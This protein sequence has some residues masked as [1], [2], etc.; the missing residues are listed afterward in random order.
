MST[1]AVTV[2]IPTYNRAFLLEASLE[3]ILA[4][5]LSPV[6]V[7]V[8]DDGSSD[9]TPDL[10]SRMR[11]RIEH[12]RVPQGGKSRAV[13]AGLPLVR[14][15]YLWVFDDDDIAAP[16]ALQRFVAPLRVDSALGFTFSRWWYTPGLPDGGLGQPRG[17]SQMPDVAKRGILAPLLEANFI[18]GASLFGRSSCYRELGGF[19][20][21]MLRSQD[22]EFAVRMARRYRGA[23]VPGGPTFHLRLHPGHRG[24]ESDRF[25]AS[26]M[27]AKWLEYDQLFFRRL[28]VEL[29]L[30]AYLPPRADETAHTRRALLQR[31]VVMANRKLNDYVLADLT[32]LAYGDDQSALRSEELELVRRGLA[33]R[34]YYGDGIRSDARLLEALRRLAAESRCMREIYTHLRRV[35]WRDLRGAGRTL[36]RGLLTADRRHLER[37]FERARVYARHVMNCR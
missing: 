1:P 34:S 11:P 9:E 36:A 8:I 7:L 25:P 31:A 23:P 21:S 3:S 13:N 5:T 30:R 17:M 15:D 33:G 19:D 22:Y 4:Q 6:Q 20:P 12:L 2:L 29:P 18:S 26:A 16:D 28:Y 27:K 24:A 32:A 37:G 10:L 35:I 14:G